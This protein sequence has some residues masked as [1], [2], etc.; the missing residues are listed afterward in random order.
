MMIYCDGF[1]LY[2]GEAEEILFNP[3]EQSVHK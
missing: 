1:S 2:T 3:I